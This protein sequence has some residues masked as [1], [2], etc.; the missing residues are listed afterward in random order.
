MDTR[1]AI[2]DKN[3]HIIG[4]QVTESSGK[5]IV[6]DKFGHNLGTIS[7]DGQVKDLFGH[8]KGS[9]DLTKLFK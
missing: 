3:G 9:L 5:T 1:T 8:N 7:K 2:K 6:K 4:F